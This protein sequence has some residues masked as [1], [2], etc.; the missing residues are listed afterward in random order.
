MKEEE[1]EKATGRRKKKLSKVNRNE[2]K[3]FEPVDFFFFLFLY[4]I[5]GKSKKFLKI[6]A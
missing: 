2:S 3:C 5:E 6:V 4:S 1:E